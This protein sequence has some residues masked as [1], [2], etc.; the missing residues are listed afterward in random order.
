MHFR[1]LTSR[2]ILLRDGDEKEKIWEEQRGDHGGG[3]QVSH[4]GGGQVSH[5]G[6]GRS[7]HFSQ[8]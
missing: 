5:G 1:G 4:G 3:G 6:G 7:C 2:I 8:L